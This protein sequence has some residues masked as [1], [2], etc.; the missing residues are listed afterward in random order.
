MTEHYIKKVGRK[1]FIMS[2][3]L[4]KIVYFDEGSVT[5][6]VQIVA[7]GKLEKQQNY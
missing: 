3:Y 2:E 6:Y 5:D 4:N 1:G 7:G